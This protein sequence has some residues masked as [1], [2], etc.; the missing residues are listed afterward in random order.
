MEAIKYSNT[1]NDE[2]NISK[3]PDFLIHHILSFVDV[4][5]AV[6]TCILSKRWRYI[7]TSLPFLRFDDYADSLDF[8][9]YV[10]SLRDNRCFDIRRFHLLR[11]RGSYGC[12]FIDRLRRWIIVVGRSN[13]EDIDVEFSGDISD[14]EDEL[15]VPSCVSTCKSLTKL[16]LYLSKCKI[17]LPNSISLPR[18]KC[19][20]LYKPSFDH[21]ELITKLCTNSPFL[22][23]LDLCGVSSTAPLNINISSLTLKH[24]ELRISY[25]NSIHNTLR[26]CAPNLVYLVLS[27]LDYMLLEDVSSLVT[28]DVGVQLKPRKPRKLKA[29]FPTIHAPDTLKSLKSL[30]NVKDLTMSFLPIKDVRRVQEILQEQPFQFSN[31]Q[32]LKL[33]NISLSTDSMH[34]IASLVKISPIIE[35][36]KLEICQDV[37]T[38]DNYNDSDTDESEPDEGSDLGSEPEQEMESDPHTS[39][40]GSHE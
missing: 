12:N 36:L 29:E 10:L 32:R 25:H 26:L 40:V 5:Q 11:G 31:L 35:S 15:H 23:H 4:K 17:S 9:E 38:G 1:T 39:E 8:V 18:L 24:F 20:K 22:E 13:V 28:A 19:L 3:L 14:E 34:A 6:Q 16:E 21:D 37:E 33:Q 27:N 30:H 7:W 2:D